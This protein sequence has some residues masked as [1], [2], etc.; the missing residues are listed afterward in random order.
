MSN[1]QKTDCTIQF[2]RGKLLQ[3]THK[4]SQILLKKI[5]KLSQNWRNRLT[6]QI[7]LDFCMEIKIKYQI[8]FKKLNPRY[9][10]TY[11]LH[12]QSRKIFQSRNQR[13]VDSKQNSACYMLQIGFFLTTTFLRNVGWLS[14]GCTISYSTQHKS[15]CKEHYDIFANIQTSQLCRQNDNFVWK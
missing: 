1:L 10:W 9:G 7:G 13:E 15:S 3:S 2:L 12:L 8:V 11:R 5:M 6:M 4:Y 14:M